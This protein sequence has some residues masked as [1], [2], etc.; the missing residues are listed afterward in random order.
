MT[1]GTETT[2]M[3]DEPKSHFYQRAE[4][5]GVDAGE[6][7]TKQLPLTCRSASTNRQPHRRHGLKTITFGTCVP[8]TIEPC[9][10]IVAVL[11]GAVDSV[12]RTEATSLPDSL[13]NKGLIANSLGGVH[14]S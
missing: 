13:D 14:T 11:G 12:S 8:Q 1:R 3:I 9:I 4:H 6:M 2:E 10:E 7:E 5:G